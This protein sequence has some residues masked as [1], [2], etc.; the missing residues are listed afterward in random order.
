MVSEP[1]LIV[2]V[3][4]MAKVINSKQARIEALEKRVESLEAA[5]AKVCPL[6]SVFG[7]V[8][9]LNAVVANARVFE[10]IVAKASVIE[11]LVAKLL[12]ME[13]RPIELEASPSVNPSGSGDIEKLNDRLEG[14]VSRVESLEKLPGEVTD[15]HKAIGETLETLT[16]DAKEA[17]Q[18]LQQ[19]VR[20][21]DGKIDELANRSGPG[22]MAFGRTK[23]PEPKPF[24]GARDSKVIDNFLFD[25]E[26]YF[27]ATKIDTDEQRVKVAPMY[28][29]EDAKLWWRTKVEEI[30]A[31][32]CVVAN[33]DDF[34]RE[35]R[36]QFYPENV[37]YN[38]RERITELRH[39]TSIR[40]YVR[41]FSALILTVPDM[42][43]ADR[44]HSFVTGLK[45]WAKNEVLRRGVRDLGAAITAAESLEDFS[46]SNVKRKPNPFI[47]GENRTT[48]WARGP[49]G[50][51]DRRSQPHGNPERRGWY[52]GNAERR[53]GNGGGT[54]NNS[55][56]WERNPGQQQTKPSGVDKGQGRNTPSLK[57]FLCSGPHRVAEC[58]HRGALNALR[59]AQHEA[60]TEES[61]EEEENGPAM[62][63][64]LKFF[65]TMKRQMDEQKKK[66]ER[67]L[68]YVDMLIKGKLFK[69]LVD[70]GA[71]D[72][73]MTDAVANRLGLTVER[74][75]GTMKTVNAQPTKVTGITRDIPCKLGPWSGEIPFT[76]A[77]MDDFDVVLGLDFLVDTRALPVPA[78]KC[79][80][81]LGENPCVVPVTMSLVCEKKVLS[82]MQFKKGV[83]RG[84]KSYL[85]IPLRSENQKNNEIPEP[86]TIVLRSYADV[87]PEKL[88]PTLPPEREI[89]HEIELIPGTKPPAKAPYRMAPPELAELRKQLDELLEAGFIRPSKAPFGAPVLFQ[90]KQDGSLRL[91]VDY[92]ALNKVTV[93]NKYPIPLVADLFDQLGKAK[94]FS[95]LDLRSGYHQV[96]IAKGDEAK[97]TCVTRYGAFEFLVM[98]FGLTNAPATFCT[99]MNQVF[100]E[101]LDK[102]VVVYLDDIVVYSST[103]KEHEQHLQLVFEKLRQ[104]KLFVKREK[105]A[106]GQTTIKF[107]GHI[108]EE[109]RIRM[110][111]DKVRAIQEWK[112][113][114][115]LTEL[116]SFLGL[117]NYYRR[118]IMRYS[119]KVLP[120][121]E[122]LKKTHIW[123]WTSQCQEA[124]EGMKKMLSED[125]V[126]AMPD[127]LKPFEVQT[128]A[129]DF[130]LGGVLMQ[131]GHPIA[132]ESRKL[133]ETE[134][135]YT[136]H[137]KELLA[138]LH[139][140]RTWRHYLLGSKFVVKTDN[141]AVSHFLT[142]PKLNPRQ[143]RWQEHLAEFDFHLEYKTGKSNSVADALSRRTELAV[144][145]HL[146]HMSSSQLTT[147][148]RDK[149]RQNLMKDP[150]AIALIN[151][152]KQGK[153]R[154]FLWE[155]DL[156]VA[157]KYRL[158]V[159][160]AG[161]LRKILLQ[162]CHD[163]LW[164][165]HPGWQRTLALL[166]QNYY[167]PKMEDEVRMYTKTCLICQQD[168]A[169][170]QKTAGLL[171]PLPVP[172]R[173]WES[174]SMDF[175]TGLPRVGEHDAILVVV[176]RFSKYSTFIPMP[177][178][179]SSED[180]AKAF[181]KNVVKYWGVPR[182]IVSDRDGRFLGT[183]WAELFRL[184]GS[185][186]DMST[187]Y[188]PQTDGQTER[189]NSLLEE[190][191]R[192]FIS[193][194]QKNWAS[195]LDV[196]QFCF[197][198]QRS[199]STNKSP[200]EIVTGQQPLL[201]HSLEGPYKGRNPKA[202]NFFKEWRQNEEIA[203]A[204]LE[205][206]S[207]RMKH[208]ADMNRRPQEFQVGDMVLIKIIP[209]QVRLRNKDKR[210][211][212]RYEGP[213]PIIEKVGTVAYKVELPQG[214]NIH[215]VLHVSNLRPYHADK[216]DARRNKVNRPTISKLE[217][218]L[219]VVEE[220]LA[221]RVVAS[222]RRKYK[223]Y[224]V[225]WKDQGE[226]ENSWEREEDIQA[227][228]DKIEQF[229]TAQSTRASTA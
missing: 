40:E 143:A 108:V 11:P 4:K 75:G 204:H 112:T 199:S 85:A 56:A 64:A 188:H 13:E 29:E 109:G 211:L 162:E 83:K 43:E 24:S 138:V 118:F 62:M 102:F 25:L 49:Y 212:R 166:T 10:T 179:S 135:R 89:D 12:S 119:E 152:A 105:C 7:K 190:Y 79:L 168:K 16:E 66:R 65:A 115:S 177:K 86:L 155:D 111:Q 160:K 125:P 196:A 173:P 88:P 8:E 201:P 225:K 3:I 161:N 42:A 169:D 228:K 126:L 36:A 157:N 213:V 174:V 123:E 170:R 74:G 106:F 222:N 159:P 9:L 149:I 80:L 183:F 101:Y 116:R 191:L 98:P 54:R 69:A 175:I 76:I 146:A 92:R 70:T 182:S 178:L 195:L 206:A 47:E 223:E 158:Y 81:I 21:V 38:S 37:W 17:I 63:G 133:S 44:V 68:M 207:Q 94:Y 120:L 14:L 22:G 164:A 136:A 90:K 34:K 61:Q 20:A 117:A 2:I 144:M 67:G 5:V 110:D 30:R 95:K 127:M 148:I 226:E 216:E 23:I 198:S 229:I 39:T 28:I 214:I 220:I 122:L 140:L 184:L 176:D 185:R 48:K 130:A 124:F 145:K 181:F 129:S 35:L 51:S 134:R 100:H 186:L 192:H 205:R 55:N 114:T 163:T 32:R 97:T 194:S 33:W 91:C 84:E 50:N 41:Q 200:F 141:T 202:Y 171:Q 219:R 151:L 167:W 19:A 103:L 203:K 93:R 153:T 26:I 1:K 137:E 189:F 221:A 73:F 113:P 99:L 132:F 180:T 128:D 15:N 210:L 121:T 147:S 193:S 131:E 18:S 197:N 58:P 59:A 57:C 6:E 60:N 208:W 107:L 46:E 52:F 87:M 78:A 172:S 104:N 215:P 156:L 77:S 53:F 165:G 224:L 27:E 209:E 187:S 227:S 154:Q 71:T 218:A 142:Q 31:G 72:N 96:R 82:A 45:P 217:S 150:Q 139:C